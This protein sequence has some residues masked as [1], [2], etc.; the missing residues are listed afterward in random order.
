MSAKVISTFNPSISAADVLLTW[1]N[2]YDSMLFFQ[3]GD[4]WMKDN[5]RKTD[6]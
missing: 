6:G 1:G 3:T 4:S 5:V 2:T